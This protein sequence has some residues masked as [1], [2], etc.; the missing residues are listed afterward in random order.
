[1]RT[2]THV[3]AIAI[4]LCAASA[5]A[6][7]Q[8]DDPKCKD[9]PVL[10]RMPGYWIHSC[11]QK[12]FDAYAFTVA[13]GKTV[14]VEGQLWKINYYPQADWKQ[15]PSELQ[16]QRNAEN[17]IQAAGGNELYAEKSR[18]TFK[19]TREGREIWVEVK[20]EFT[21]K[22]FLAI[23]QKAPMAQDLVASA[24]FLAQGLQ[25]EGHMAVNGIYFDTAKAVL[26]PESAQA[27][28]EIAKLLKA[29][30]ALKVFVVGHTDGVGAVEPNL[31][32]S[33]DRAQAVL[34]A[35]VREH[36]IDAGRL[37]AHGCGP[38]APVATNDTDA[39]R[40]RNRRVELVKQ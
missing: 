3:L 5:G 4:L 21:G 29:D 18:Q 19:L 11:V 40:A 13:K 16:I 39:G 23:V 2:L 32:L 38:F 9:H 36:G 25:T 24:E 7:E 22:Y 31:K 12:E 37:R 26:K 20:E 1:M 35:L 15:K 14:S 17:A 8:K 10:T 34:Q 33:Q 27:V 28:G 30:P 6:L